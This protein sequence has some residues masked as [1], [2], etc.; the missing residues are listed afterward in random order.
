[1]RKAAYVAVAVPLVVLVVTTGV[2]GLVF[3]TH[4]RDENG[5]VA[6][7]KQYGDLTS[8]A[9]I[10][11]LPPRDALVAEG[12]RA[13]SWLQGQSYALWR[14]GTTFRYPAVQDRYVATLNGRHP[15]WAGPPD[16]IGVMTAA[17]AYLCPAVVEL[18]LPHH[19]T[20]SA[21]PGD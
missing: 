14:R 2:V 7:L 4:P 3:V 12:D 18:H 11:V 20:R 15:P 17:W 10:P 16:G 21:P 13:C 9:P 19:L 1:M 8:D 6:Y 5:Y